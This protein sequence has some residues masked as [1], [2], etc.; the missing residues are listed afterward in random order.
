M[1]IS[2]SFFMQGCNISVFS[3]LTV[4]Q[5]IILKKYKL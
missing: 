1:E 5:G 3:L 2:I 4:Q